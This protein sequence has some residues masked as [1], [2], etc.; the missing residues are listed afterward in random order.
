[1]GMNSVFK[2][3]TPVENEILEV[4]KAA[5]PSSAYVHGFENYAGKILVPTKSN[6]ANLKRQVRSLK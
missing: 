4:W 3:M 2:K 1:M 6:L 5:Y